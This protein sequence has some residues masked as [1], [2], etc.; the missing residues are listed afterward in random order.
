MELTV[1]FVGISFV[2][3]VAILFFGFEQA[4]RDRAERAASNALREAADPQGRTADEVVFDIEHR[5]DSDLRDVAS[6]LGLP[7]SRVRRA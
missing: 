7:S 2:A 5:I 1:T 6:L 3:M 4:E